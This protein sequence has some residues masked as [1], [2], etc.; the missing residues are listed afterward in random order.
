MNPRLLQLARE[1]RGLSQ[2]K[3]ASQ[4]GLSQGTLSKAENGVSP[5]TPDRLATIAELLDYPLDMLSWPDDPVGLGPSGFY[6]RKQSGLGKTA[7]QRIEAEVNLLLMQLRRLEASVEI[8]PPFRL[9]VLDADEHE[10]EE[11]ASKVRAS[12]MIP[13]GPV[14]D[15]IRTVERAGIIV[16]RRDLESPK[17][18][19][20]SVRP[21]NGMPVIILNEGMPP[22]RE[23]FTVL[24]ELGHLVMHQ[25]PSDD[26]ER[27]ADRFAAEFLMPARLI[28]PQLSGMTLQKAIQLKQYWKA[29]M[30]SIIQTARYLGRIDDRRYKSLQVQISQHGYR[31]NEPAEPPQENP[32]ILP[33]MVDTHRSDHG[34]SDTE[35][36]GVVG[37]KLREFHAEYGARQGL[38]A[39]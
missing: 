27:E 2:S 8:D 7:L 20:L 37:L 3:L 9:P 11:A 24:H 23:R 1:S 30:A 15:V 31:R 26:G 14:H 17:I 33:S 21:P 29:S 22:A 4:A 10:P 36:A 12:W 5:L 34:Y 35:L 39:V 32:R 6:H 13:D 25:L 38:R 19:G 18:S 16:V 28:G